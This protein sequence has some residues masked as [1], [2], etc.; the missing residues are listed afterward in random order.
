MSSLLKVQSFAKINIGLLVKDQR[1]DGYHNIHTVYQ[2]ISLSDTITLRK[3]SQG[4]ELSSNVNWV[5]TD[6]TNLCVKAYLALKQRYKQVEGISIHLEKTIPAGAGLGGGSSNAAAVLKGLNELY[7]L[8]ISNEEL[9]RISSTLGADVPFFIKGKTQIG[10]GIGDQLSLSP[11]TIPGVYLV[12]VPNIHIDTKWA[13]GELKKHL[14]NRPDSI[15]FA[16]RLRD[17]NLSLSIFENDFERIV[18]PAY[19]EIGKIKERLIESGAS[20]ASLSGSGSAV[21][22]IFDDEASTKEAESVFLS[23]YTFIAHPLNK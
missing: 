11:H 2:E 10:N 19:P 9:E 7:E 20:F 8:S 23:H 14:D 12:V 22:G 6:E 16:T 5:P 21:Y 3:Q 17:N 15:N 18:I 13:Y 4:W 1:P